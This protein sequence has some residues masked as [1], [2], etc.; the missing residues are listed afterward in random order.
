MRRL[1]LSCE[2]GGNSVPAPFDAYFRGAAAVLRSHR[3]WDPGA[4][5]L[6]D[7]LRPLAEGSYLATLSR[8]VIELNRS[9]HHPR[10]F[11]EFSRR[12]PESYKQWLV[13]EVHRPYRAAL[14]DDVMA[15]TRGGDEV[16]HIG[17]HSFAPVLDGVRRTMDIGLLYDPRRPLERRFCHVFA[18]ALKVR[19]PGLVVRMNA[20]YKG[21]SDGVTKYL[22]S[23]AD[24]G[25]AGIELEVNQRFATRSGMHPD[26]KVVVAAALQAAVHGA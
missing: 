10:L 12:F 20:P 11:S 16:V 4:Q 25:Y 13:R 3:G 26:I 14:A 1:F 23:Q 24:A 18:Q 6:F 22:R 7:A 9:E 17:V 21:V 5:D 19:A 15:A 2:H 8:L